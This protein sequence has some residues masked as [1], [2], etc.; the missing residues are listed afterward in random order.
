MK[1]SQKDG[2]KSRSSNRTNGALGGGIHHGANDSTVGSTAVGLNNHTSNRIS[3]H[4]TAQ[5]NRSSVKRVNV[6][7][8]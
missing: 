1:S 6:N 5:Q 3:N 7:V 2:M 4:Q 8:I